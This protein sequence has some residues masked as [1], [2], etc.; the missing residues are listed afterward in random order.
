M[1]DILPNINDSEDLLSSSI[2]DYLLSLA[3]SLHQVQQELSEFQ[4]AGQAG[5]PGV[6]YQLPKLDFELKMAIRLA[7]TKQTGKRNA[8]LLVRPIDSFSSSSRSN[9][10]DTASTIKGS[11]IAIPTNGGKPPAVIRSSLKR[12]NARKWEINVEVLSAVGQRLE[13]VEVQ[14]NL[15]REESVR[16]SSENKLT[17]ELSP[18]TNLWYGVVQTSEDGLAQDVLEASATELIGSS[19]VVM[20]DVLGQSETLVFKVEA[21]DSIVAPDTNKLLRHL[22]KDWE[23]SDEISF[24]FE[25]ES[26]IRDAFEESLLG[27]LKDIVEK[28]SQLLDSAIFIQAFQEE[29]EEYKI[30]SSNILL[31]ELNNWIPNDSEDYTS[32]A[33][34]KEDFLDQL[35]SSKPL[36]NRIK[37]LGAID[38]VWERDRINVSLKQKFTDHYNLRKNIIIEG[39]EDGLPLSKIF[40]STEELRRAYFKEKTV[41]SNVVSLESVL[42][43]DGDIQN[44]LKDI[45]YQRLRDQLIKEVETWTVGG[46]HVDVEA[47]KEKFFART[48][49]KIIALNERIA[50]MELA[51]NRDVRLDIAVQITFTEKFN[52]LEKIS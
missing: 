36:E 41:I 44:L 15:L 7:E 37:V 21:E 3:D 33:S 52:N 47:L 2:E 34:M 48:A 38:A 28:Q 46:V 23:P 9:V 6:R 24:A 19:L 1:S 39:L 25:E 45:L 14:F 4:V 18:Q 12:Q 31:T 20:V 30:R 16:L 27:E 43:E 35:D 5:Q 17:I 26:Q 42:W 40:E 49:Q 51:Q 8:P 11:F 32:E 10:A 22:K 29:L 13:G 50:A